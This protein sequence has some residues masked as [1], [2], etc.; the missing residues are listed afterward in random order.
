MAKW[1]GGSVSAGRTERSFSVFGRLPCG[2]ERFGVLL[3]AIVLMLA[4]NSRA[5]WSDCCECVTTGTTAP[6]KFCAPTEFVP[7]ST[8]GGT[9]DD[10]DCTAG[11]VVV[12]GACEGGTQT[13]APGGLGADCVPPTPTVT[14][15]VTPTPIRP[16]APVVSGG[17]QGLVAI[18]L[19]VGGLWVLRRSWKFGS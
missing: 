19:L 2:V 18:G 14:P 7:I 11:A 13:G 6:E 5:A 4:L 3:G 16:V 10:I 15:T 17:N 8:C 1:Q 12:G 9:L